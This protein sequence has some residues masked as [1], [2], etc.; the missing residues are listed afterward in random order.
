QHPVI[1]SDVTELPREGTSPGANQHAQEWVE[2][3]HSDEEAPE[4]AADRAGR[5]QIDRLVKLRLSFLVSG[6]DH[7]VLKVDQI[8][9]LHLRKLRSHVERCCLVV[10]YD[11]YESAHNV[12]SLVCALSTF[13]G[14]FAR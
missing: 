10:E 1:E 14:R 6:H 2:E 12:C 4:A 13:A 5:R 9:L 7:R 8:F 3:D 11:R